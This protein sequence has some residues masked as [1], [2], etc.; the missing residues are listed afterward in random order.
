MQGWNEKA[1]SGDMRVWSD[2]HGNVLTLAVP[3]YSLLSARRGA[4]D[5]LYDSAAQVLS[6]ARA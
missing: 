4:G 1:P 2:R 5:I 6:R 3:D